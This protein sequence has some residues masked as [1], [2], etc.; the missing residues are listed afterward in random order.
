MYKSVSKF[1]GS[2]VRST[3]QCWQRIQPGLDDLPRSGRP[4]PDHPRPPTHH[5]TGN[6]GARATGRGGRS[7]RLSIH[8]WQENAWKNL[9]FY[10]RLCHYWVKAEMI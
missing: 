8:Y 9:Y 5:T 1:L 2:S 3:E 6:G 4:S 10:M 7:V